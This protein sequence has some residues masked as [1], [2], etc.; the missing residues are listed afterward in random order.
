MA[1]FVPRL[2]DPAVGFE[3]KCVIGGAGAKGDVVGDRY[4]NGNV[5]VWVGPCKEARSDH[6]PP[7]GGWA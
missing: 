3:F 6:R 1:K 4:C 5:D 2:V 7:A